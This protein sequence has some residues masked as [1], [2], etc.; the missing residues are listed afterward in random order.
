MLTGDAEAPARRI[1]KELGVGYRARLLPEQKVEA[2]RELVSGHGDV[3]MVGDGVNDAPALAASSVGFAMGAAGTDVALETADVALMQDDLPKLA[4]AVRLSRA[5]ERIIKQ[6]VVVSIAIKGLFVLLAPFGLVALWLA[7]LADMGTS[8]AVTLNG[9]RLFRKGKPLGGVSTA[10]TAA[11]REEL[12]RRGL[13]LE[14]FTVAWNVVEAVVAIGVGL[15]VGS[16]AL[17]G[18]GVDSGIEVISAVALLWRLYRAGPNAS[19]Q[20]HG[21][22]E[23]KALYLVV[24]TFFLLAAY[25]LYEAVGALLSGEGPETS[26]VALVL[27]VLSILIMPTL[28]YFKGRTGRAMGS[29][30]LVAD[31]VET[32]VCA[33][34]SVALLAAVGLNAAFGWWWADPL[35]ALAM[36]PVILWQGW[37]TLGEAREGNDDDDYSLSRK[38]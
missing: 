15:A 14:W 12:H 25:I 17:V 6:N 4:E 5:A 32:W 8:I 9:L 33:Y 31:S 27:S 11:R 13:W 34:L 22:A 26:R 7:V 19:A 29:R 28:A 37:E 23:R 2:V 10:P 36:L 35:G 38:G 30:A 3:G 21:D 1:A 20:E 16:V 18:F 24:A